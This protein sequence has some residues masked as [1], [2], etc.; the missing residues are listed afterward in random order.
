MVKNQE[1]GPKSED[2]LDMEKDGEFTTVTK[3]RR[4]IKASHKRRSGSGALIIG[5]SN[6]YR[7][8][9]AARNEYNIDRSMFKC[10]P[11]IVIENVPNKL[12]RAVQEVGVK[13]VDVVLH[14][15]S[16]DLA[17]HRS[18]DYVLEGLATTIESSLMLQNVRDVVVC[19]VEERHDAGKDVYQNACGLNEQLSHLCS[20]YGAKFLDLRRRLQECRFGGINRTG[21]L[22][23]AEGSHN[24]SQLL[25]SEVSGFLD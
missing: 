3:R 11:G 14:V 6:V 5:G 9:I 17:A 10:V 2:V 15:G 20:T 19:S 22:Y 13:E 24:V 4:N 12:A 23:T 8:S 18:V 16:D 7:I 1:T 21:V 25:M